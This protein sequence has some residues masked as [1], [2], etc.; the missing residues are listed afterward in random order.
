[1]EQLRDDVERL[2]QRIE[3]LAGVEKR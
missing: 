3:R 1:V 2:E